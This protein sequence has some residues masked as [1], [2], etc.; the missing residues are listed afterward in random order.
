MNNHN[1]LNLKKRGNPTT[2]LQE[3]KKYHTSQWGR[4]QVTGCESLQ[5][6][7]IAVVLF[8]PQPDCSLRNKRP[9]LNLIDCRAGRQADRVPALICFSVSTT[10]SQNSNSDRLCAAPLRSAAEEMEEEVTA[11]SNNCCFCCRG[12]DRPF[13]TALHGARSGRGMKSAWRI[14][15]QLHGIAFKLLRV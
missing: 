13:Q 5:N 6:K 12:T 14:R 10:T 8:S 1:N 2:Q 3:M 9:P 4:T 15:A 7:T 11:D